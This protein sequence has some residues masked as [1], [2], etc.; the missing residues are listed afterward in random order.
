MLG[1]YREVECVGEELLSRVAKGRYRSDRYRAHEFVS[2]NMLA[3]ITWCRLFLLHADDRFCD[4][5]E[6]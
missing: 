3:L 4:V 2:D 5:S 1:L 6:V